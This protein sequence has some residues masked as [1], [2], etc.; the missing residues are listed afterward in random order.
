MEIKLCSKCLT[1]KSIED[2]GKNK[3]KSDGLEPRCRECVN[4]TSRERYTKNPQQKIAQTRKYHL[5][6]PEWSK[7]R[8]R[9]HHEANAEARYERQKLRLQDPEKRAKA[10]ESS[11][12]SEA[13]RRAIKKADLADFIT[14]KE[15]TELVKD[16]GNLCY[17]CGDE[18]SDKIELQLDHYMPISKGGQHTL[19]NLRPACS[20]CNRR[21]NSIWPITD[22]ILTRIK[23]VTL[24]R[25]AL[26]S[27]SKEVMPECL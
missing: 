23:I 1:E 19:S 12:R 21:K 27:D 10:R 17:I 7:Q 16:S 22:V 18:F 2:F 13:R 4:K 14:M 6:H 24:E 26:C 5:E 11:R 25:R 3:R 15:I 8:L 20:D 9:A